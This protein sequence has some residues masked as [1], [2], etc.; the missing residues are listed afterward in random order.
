MSK[1]GGGGVCEVQEEGGKRERCRAKGFAPRNVL[2]CTTAENGSGCDDAP[3][4]G[5]QNPRKWTTE[6]AV[7]AE[8]EKPHGIYCLNTV[9]HVA[10]PTEAPRM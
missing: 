3:K 7:T 9:S 5:H 4:N 10:L 1:K 6:V 2:R 8:L